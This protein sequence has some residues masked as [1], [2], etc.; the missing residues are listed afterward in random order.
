MALHVL[1]G[2]KNQKKNNILWCQNYFM[3]TLV[4]INK[5]LLEPSH[6]H[7]FIYGPWLLSAIMVEWLKQRHYSLHSLKYLLSGPWTAPPQKK[8][9]PIFALE[10]NSLTQ[11]SLL[12]I[13]PELIQITGGMVSWAASRSPEEFEIGSLLK[14]PEMRHLEVDFSSTGEFLKFPRLFA[15][16]KM[17]RFEDYAYWMF[18]I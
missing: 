3:F 11:G 1:S 16:T 2:W 13:F 10:E 6:A 18:N 17:V 8:S 4:S 5:V 15:Q 12:W 14:T 9:L 7:F